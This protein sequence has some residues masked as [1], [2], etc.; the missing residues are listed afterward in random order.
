[1][2][3]PILA[4][5]L[6]VGATVGWYLTVQGTEGQGKGGLA[7]LRFDAACVAEARP[8]L[9]SRLTDLGLEPK[10]ED[11]LSFV[12]RTPGLPDDLEHLPKA[13]VRP[14]TLEVAVHGEPKAVTID[15][16]GVQL[17]F[18]GT[19]V[20]LV[21][22]KD[23][24]SEEGL[25]VKVDGEPVELESASGLELLIAARGQSSTD[26][27]RLA[28]DRAV[29]LRYPLPCPVTAGRAEAVGP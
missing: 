19:P 20:T 26:A 21:L 24:V 10:A 12:V 9:M 4:G 28:T 2:A 25:T 5:L 27:L 6:L 17:A 16:V 22:L 15:N 23:A 14:G 13:L 7:R 8:A 1:M 3:A 11:A 18:S 29:A